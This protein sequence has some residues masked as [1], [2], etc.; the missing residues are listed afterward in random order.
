[1]R[2]RYHDQLKRM[3]ALMVEM[4]SLCQEAIGVSVKTLSEKEEAA[5]ELEARVFAVDNEIDDLER[6]I[7]TL[8][9][10]LLLLQQPVATDL[11]RITAALKMITDLE[12]IG[13][14]ASDIAELSSFIRAAGDKDHGHLEQM[15]QETI[16]MVR[17]SVDAFIRLDLDLAQSVIAYDDVVD[18]WFH[19][20]KGELIEMIAADSRRGE[21][22]LDI[23]MVAKYLERIGD[24]ATNLAEWVEYAVTG[25]RSKDGEPYHPERDRR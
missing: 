24:H 18:G 12:R 14:Q 17:E 9:T 4:G 13:D 21:E 22:Y 7:E 11:R 10:K 23:L 2:V 5:R 25:Q 20:I 1:M 19:R 15:A 16:R 6:E 3:Y 8:C